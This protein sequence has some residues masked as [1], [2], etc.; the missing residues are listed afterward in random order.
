MPSDTVTDLN[1]GIVV[2]ARVGSTRLPAKMI[3]PFAEHPTLAGL[4]LD[5]LKEKFGAERIILATSDQPP[6][7]QL[8]E[9]VEGKGISVYRGSEKDVLHRFIGAANT[10]NLTHLVRVCADNPFLSVEFLDE[11]TEEGIRNPEADYISW[12]FPDGTPT[13]RSHCGFFAEW[14]SVKAL[15]QIESSTDEMFFHE[16]I[17]S[18]IFDHP[19]EFRVHRLPVPEERREFFRTVR[20]TIDTESDFE[21]AETIFRALVAGKKPITSE[22]VYSYLQNR[23]DLQNQMTINI[24]QNGK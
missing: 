23:P 24:N 19:G 16:H 9:L 4:I 22:S 11:L 12:F 3:R 14:A 20:L 1:W 8:A 13:I 17:T 5:R 6:D 10:Q 2:Q 18:Y 15:L 7:D 21:I